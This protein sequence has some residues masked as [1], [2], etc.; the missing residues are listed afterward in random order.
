MT[1][2][3]GLAALIAATLLGA[4]PEMVRV[5]A[6]NCPIGATV[7][8]EE[9]HKEKVG[10]FLIA[11]TP[12]TNTEYKR[13]VDDAAH[14]PPERNSV[15]NSHHWWTGKTFPPQIADS[16]VVNVSWK[17]AEA[18][19]K[20]LARKTGKPYRLPT[21]EEWEIAARGGLKGKPYPWGDGIDKSMAWY[22]MKWIGAGTL[23]PADYGRANPYGLY[24]MA[25][26]VWQ[27]VDDWYV[28][29]FNDR[30]VQEELKMFK[31]IRGG[32][33]ANDE[34]FLKVDYRNFHPPDFKDFF[35]GFRVA[36]SE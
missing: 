33:W 23:M 10:G 28:P 6:A 31:V 34:G 22:G 19:C 20:W 26:N 29:T 7:S 16:P 15:G 27:W 12:V 11:R 9:I 25:G 30:P 24:G 4:E 21:E 1:K 2:A 36:I 5:P 3:T 13:F 17:D 35:V 8:H 14:P 18:Y 32:S